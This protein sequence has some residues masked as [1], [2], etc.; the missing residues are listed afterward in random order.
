M[1]VA[2]FENN[3]QTLKAAVNCP[4]KT[5]LLKL[6]I[7]E[8][9]FLLVIAATGC[10]PQYRPANWKDITDE[11]GQLSENGA[12]AESID[13]LDLDR[14]G[15]LTP[16][17]NDAPLQNRQALPPRET[18]TLPGRSSI[19]PEDYT[20]LPSRARSIKLG[21]LPDRQR[22]TQEF[23]NGITTMPSA[24]NTTLPLRESSNQKPAQSFRSRSSTTL[25]SRSNRN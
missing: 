12:G 3:I 18:S 13:T 8:S 1:G 20:T 5:T 16:W 23:R 2:I 17:G 19:Q 25:P 24:G 21:T 9:L 6:A 22:P 14:F 15:E 10:Q 4:K 11:V 7:C